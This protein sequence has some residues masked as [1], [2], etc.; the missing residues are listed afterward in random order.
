[1]SEYV[2]ETGAFMENLI[3]IDLEAIEIETESF[4]SGTS[5]H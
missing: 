4:E 5:S 3:T 2:L 1:M